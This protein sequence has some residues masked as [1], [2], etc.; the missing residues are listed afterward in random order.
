MDVERDRARYEADRRK[1][2]LLSGDH[3]HR[4]RAE[5]PPARRAAVSGRH[6]SGDCRQARVSD[7][8]RAVRARGER[9][10]A[11]V[12]RTDSTR[13]RRRSASAFTGTACSE[14]RLIAL[15]YAFEQATRRRV[16]PQLFP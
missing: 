16:P 6:R 3:G 5:G 7:R 4:R 11:P 14:P 12:S 13:D 9:A 10:D 1:D 2:V 8:D 15:A